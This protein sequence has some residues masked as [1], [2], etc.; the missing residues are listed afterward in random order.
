MAF[1]GTVTYATATSSARKDSPLHVDNS[2]G[3]EFFYLQAQEMIASIFITTQACRN[4]AHGSHL[5][6]SEMVYLS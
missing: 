4:L 5:F 2:V 3:I 1:V 6:R